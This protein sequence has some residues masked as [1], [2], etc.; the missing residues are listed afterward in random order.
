M[1]SWPS[2]STRRLVLRR[3]NLD[4]AGE[5]KRLAGDRAVADTVANIPHPYEDGMAEEWI[6]GHEAEYQS[7]TALSLA[8]V[9]K[10]TQE[11]VGAIGLH[12][13]AKHQYAEFGYW[14]G[15]PYWNNGFCT[16]AAQALVRYCFDELNL[17]RIQA[18]HMT[19]NPASGRVMQKVG[20]R[21]EGILR[22]QL[23]RWDSYEDMAIYGIIAS[24]YRQLQP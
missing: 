22:Q 19:K 2:L 23:R 1:K 5:V 10:K 20:M 21:F 4:D 15:K 24:D 9:L 3:F 14:I 13:T 16:E 11:L 7:G 8:I 17:N 6:G 18:R 12:I